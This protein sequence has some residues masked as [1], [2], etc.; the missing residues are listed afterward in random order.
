[1]R[2]YNALMLGQWEIIRNVKRYRTPLTTRC[3][4]RFYILLHP[5]IMGPYCAQSEGGEGGGEVLA[6]WRPADS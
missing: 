5:F 2:Q 3:F 6:P 4:A 1:L